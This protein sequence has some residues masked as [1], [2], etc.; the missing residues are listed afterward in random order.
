MD[1]NTTDF[2]VELILGFFF[3][4]ILSWFV[5]LLPA[6]FYRYVVFKGP[7]DSKKVFWRLAPIVFVF[8]LAF[9]M[10]VSEL[11]GT[12]PN[13]NPIPWIIIYY[14]GKWIMT[15]P[16]K[17]QED[18]GLC[19]KMIG[20]LIAVII[21]IAVYFVVMFVAKNLRHYEDRQTAIRTVQQDSHVMDTPTDHNLKTQD[22]SSSVILSQNT[23]SPEPSISSED[24]KFTKLKLPLGVSVDVPKNWRILEGDLNSTI[25]TTAEAVMSLSGVELPK[26]KK[27]NLFRANSVSQTTYAGIAINATD[28]ELAPNELMIASEEEIRELSPLMHEMMQQALAAQNLKVIEFY[29][30]RREFVGKHPALI[31][32]YKRSGPQGAVIVQMTRLFLGEKEISLNLSYRE[33]E[34]QI[35]K[36]IIQYIRRSLNVS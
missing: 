12:R 36:P 11:S 3:G 33:S 32:E 8:M 20:K 29:G 16:P 4:W 17:L 28:S 18:H 2:F 35:W 13:G 23:P 34:A 24:S 14:I 26:G 27:V 10:T 22:L 6:L 21:I 19:N 31:I 9:K 15:R 30:V 1:T 25:E 7:I 5:G